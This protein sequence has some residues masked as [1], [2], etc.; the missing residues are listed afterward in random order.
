MFIGSECA[1]ELAEINATMNSAVPPWMRILENQWALYDEVMRGQETREAILVEARYPQHPGGKR[2]KQ[3]VPVSECKQPELITHEAVNEILAKDNITDDDKYILLKYAWSLYISNSRTHQD[4]LLICDILYRTAIADK[5]TLSSYGYTLATIVS[6]SKDVTFDKAHKI[7]MHDELSELIFTNLPWSSKILDAKKLT[8][9][10]GETVVKVDGDNIMF[11]REINDVK[12]DELIKRI[13]TWVNL[14]NGLLSRNEIKVNDLDEA[15]QRLPK[16]YPKPEFKMG[17]IDNYIPFPSFAV[18]PSLNIEHFNYDVFSQ[19]MFDVEWIKNEILHRPRKME[20]ILNKP[21]MKYIEQLRRQHANKFNELKYSTDAA[22]ILQ[23]YASIIKQLFI[24]GNDCHNLYIY[25]N[26][27]NILLT[28]IDL[29]GNT[30]ARNGF[31]FN[32]TAFNILANKCRILADVYRAL[33]H[34]SLYVKAAKF[35][36]EVATKPNTHL[37]AEINPITMFGLPSAFIHDRGV[38]CIKLEDKQR[39]VVIQCKYKSVHYADLVGTYCM[40]NILKADVDVQTKIKP[41]ICYEQMTE[42]IFL[43]MQQRTMPPGY[44]EKDLYDSF[45]R[46]LGIDE[47]QYAGSNK[48]TRSSPWILIMLCI[49]SVAIIMVVIIVACVYSR[50]TF[51]HESIQTR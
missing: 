46:A 31:K 35:E 32:T 36:Y 39:R 12:K 27:H 45:I 17:N 33:P 24:A 9:K 1:D 41:P 40:A 6:A 18:L 25:N 3:L 49:L 29:S 11:Y 38:D 14:L 44:I 43:D 28:L 34:V 7:Y 10:F 30:T 22:T 15:R 42:Q 16:F 2:E 21:L 4:I 23:L 8:M 19:L 51:H 47:E 20:N 50:M 5:D 26:L 37:W 48:V 13:R